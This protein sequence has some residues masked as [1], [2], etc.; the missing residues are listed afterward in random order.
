MQG[1]EEA[2]MYRA[3]MRQGWDWD[4]ICRGERNIELYDNEHA[5][6]SSKNNDVQGRDEAGMCRAGLR[7]GCAGQGW[8]EAGMCRAGLMVMEMY[9]LAVV[10]VVMK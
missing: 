2:R 10:V 8:E 6:G 9:P 5:Y 7:Q 4:L 1:W 3:G